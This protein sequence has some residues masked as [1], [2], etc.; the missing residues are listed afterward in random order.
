MKK[1]VY[2]NKTATSEIISTHCAVA[3]FLSDIFI[4]ISFIP[5]LCFYDQDLRVRA[6]E[7]RVLLDL[8]DICL[9]DDITGPFSHGGLN[10]MGS[11]HLW[12]R[13]SISIFITSKY[14]IR[15]FKILILVLEDISWKCRGIRRIKPQKIIDPIVLNVASDVFIQPGALVLSVQTLYRVTYFHW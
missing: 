4:S 3:M 14:N 5:L 9:T 13:F 15:A 11:K 7:Y 10:T 6:E 2:K 8:R 1:Q 12:S